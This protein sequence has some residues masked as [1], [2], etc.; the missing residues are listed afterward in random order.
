M[1]KYIYGK[2]TEIGEQQLKDKKDYEQLRGRS[3]H[4][5]NS[6]NASPHGRGKAVRIGIWGVLLIAVLIMLYF[7][8]FN[9]GGGNKFFGIKDSG[10]GNEAVEN[11][12]GA[13][14]FTSND[15]DS[16]GADTAVNQAHN[17]GSTNT[18]TSGS[19]GTKGSGDNGN[20]TANDTLQ[21]ADGSSISGKGDNSGADDEKNS[22]AGS[23][24]NGD[25]DIADKQP[26]RLMFAGDVYP[27]N[28][29]MDAYNA[30]GSIKGVVSESYLEDIRDSDFF[31]VNEEFPF[32]SRGTQAPD[33]QFTFRV[34][35][36]KVSMFREMDI[37]LVTLANNHALDYGTEALLDSIDTLDNADIAHVGAGKDL[38]AARKPVIAELNGR[39]FA[40]IGA[41]RVIPVAEWAAGTDR[42]GM[43]SAYDG[44]AQLAESV[45]AAKQHADYVVVYMHWGIERDEVTNEVQ[46]NIAH[47]IIDAGADLVVG[48]HPHVLQGLEYYKGVPIAYSLGNFVFG[49]QIPSTALLQ[50]DVDDSGIRLRLIPGSSAGGYTK[51]T[52]DTASVAAF[53]DKIKGLSKGVGIDVDGYVY[54]E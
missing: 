10:I 44:G 54:A 45:K 52:E 34:A 39:T 11:A 48:A 7:T 53:Y 25:N 29:V 24:D 18:D 3:R 17:D 2:E 19:A 35:P 15:K 33:K 12:S 8:V 4:R 22:K 6:K 16:S 20:G 49:S 26:V 37:D 36:D 38:E 30:A 51:K 21:D 32:S 46:R 14:A 9:P 28:Y 42:P 50:A 13:D 47:N 43:F 41:T 5:D 40:F 23:K 31:I 1:Y 27:S